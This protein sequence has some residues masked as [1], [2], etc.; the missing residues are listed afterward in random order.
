M[1][2][3]SSRRTWLALGSLNEDFVTFPTGM[4]ASGSGVD[5]MAGEDYAGKVRIVLIRGTDVRGLLRKREIDERS[6]G[7]IRAGAGDTVC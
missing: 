3:L 1:E 5:A 4:D 7:E 2:S 6:S